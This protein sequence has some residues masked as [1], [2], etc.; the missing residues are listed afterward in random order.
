MHEN[1]RSEGKEGEEVEDGEDERIYYICIDEKREVR[2]GRCKE[3]EVREED[4]GRKEL[5]QRERWRERG[6]EEERDS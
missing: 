6:R 4:E 2:E 1:S 3:M 5:R